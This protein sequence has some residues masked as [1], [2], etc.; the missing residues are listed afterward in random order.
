MVEQRF[1]EVSSETLPA[2]CVVLGGRAV[3]IEARDA[4][5]RSDLALRLVDRGGSLV[6]GDQT[7]CQRQSGQ[8]IACAPSGSGGRIEVPGM[9]IVQLPHEER[10]PVSLLIVL[11]DTPPHFPEEAKRRLAGIDVPVLTLGAA[12]LAATIKVELAL[13]QFRR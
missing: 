11:V 5:A 12:E 7:V 10:A 4:A 8:L 3:L 13:G 9:G 2:A 6:A 1:P